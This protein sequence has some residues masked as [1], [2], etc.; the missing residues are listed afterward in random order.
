M[1]PCEHQAKQLPLPAGGCG[2]PHPT[3][4]RGDCRSVPAALPRV[5]ARSRART[6]YITLGRSRDR[7]RSRVAAV[8][9]AVLSRPGGSAGTCRQGES[10]Q[11]DLETSCR[12]EVQKMPCNTH[13]RAHST[14]LAQYIGCT[15]IAAIGELLGTYGT[16]SSSLDRFPPSTPRYR[17][18]LGARSVAAAVAARLRSATHRGGPPASWNGHARVCWGT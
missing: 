18:S 16:P 5:I 13:S 4:G 9:A 12:G 10:K 6:N 1:V 2:S 8:P 7:R 3:A 15:A 11:G 17:S 14:G